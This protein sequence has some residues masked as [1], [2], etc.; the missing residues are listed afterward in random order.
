M[1]RVP[2]GA[3]AAENGSLKEGSGDEGA[4]RG[5][6]G[7]VRT[8]NLK[9]G[10]A[11]AHSGRQSES[12]RCA[13]VR[14]QRCARVPLPPGTSASRARL[15]SAAISASRPPSA[16]RTDSWCHS[17]LPAPPP[18]SRSRASAAVARYQGRLRFA[19]TAFFQIPPGELSPLLVVATVAFLA[20]GP[21]PRIS[22]CCSLGLRAVQF[23]NFR[24]EVRRCSSLT[25]LCVGR[26][27]V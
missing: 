13:P 25:A 22:C 12:S 6:G 4:R 16:S 8:G 26:P 2:K 11:L 17:A 5:D 14:L 19:P 23:L 24:G 20:G 1:G 3:R 21:W 7:T 9:S 10:T 15:I 18:A 27:G